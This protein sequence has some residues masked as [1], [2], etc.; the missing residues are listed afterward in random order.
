M[1]KISN[2]GVNIPASPIRKLVPFAEEAKRAGKKIY[3][4]NI[5][6]P[7]I[8]TPK[9]ALEAVK[10]FNEPVL[11]Y[12][13]SAGFES[14]RRKLAQWFQD[15]GTN[16][17]Y[18]DIIT[19]SGG[20]EA[21][22]F[23]MMTCFDPEDEVIV[24][25]PMYANYNGFSHGA[26]VKIKPITARIE[27]NFALPPIADFEKVITPKTKAIL[28]CNPSNPTGYLYSKEELLALKKIVLKHDLFLFVDEVYRDFVYDG[29]EFTSAL[30]VEGLEQNVI[31]IDSVS[32]RYSAC[33][34]RTG[35]MISRNKE[36]I[37][38]AMK[39]AQARLSPPTLS[40]VFAEATLDTPQS[41]IEEAA[42]EYNTRRQLVVNRLNAMEGVNCPTPGG[43]FYVFVELPVDDSSKFCQWM[44]EKF[45]HNGHSVMMAPGSGFYATE[46]LGTKEVRI[47]YVLNTDALNNALDCLE[48]GLKVYQKK[49]KNTAVLS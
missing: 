16:I 9:G 8:E 35:A 46:G 32:K 22:F 18:T 27:D 28:I 36:I 41:Y 37:D 19:S 5:G 24:P 39:F 38:T 15:R 31:V 44:L 14:Y 2:R 42:K 11:A 10:N 49:I 33:G 40:Q 20:S 12:C 13:H 21:L 6:Q 23:G 29:K 48:E 43:A 47:A 4:L 25:E 3:H 1:P 17:D 7:D 34:A 26:S 30:D 45:E